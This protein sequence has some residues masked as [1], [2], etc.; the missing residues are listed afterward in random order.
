MSTSETAATSIDE[1][2]SGVELVVEMIALRHQIAAPKRCGTRRPCFRRW[3]RLFWILLS[4]WWPRWREALTIVQPETVLRWRR[5]G[6]S[7]L[8]QYRSRGRWQGG[9]PRISR[10]VRGL[11]VRM[12]RE[13]FLWGVPRIHG[14][15][16]MLGFKVSQA[17]VSRYMPKSDRRPGQSWRTFIRLQALAFTRQEDLETASDSEQFKP[18]NQSAGGT[19]L[20]VFCEAKRSISSLLELAK[21]SPSSPSSDAGSTLSCAS[22]AMPGITRAAFLRG[23]GF[24]E[25]QRSISHSYR[26]WNRNLTLTHLILPR[27][28]FSVGAAVP[29]ARG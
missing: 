7:G 9:R 15:L 18:Y 27:L 25:A 6:W 10:E 22:I 20:R 12:A 24:E 16:R 26:C 21:Q 11:I 2:R 14:E 4:R 5:T 8:W 1:S 23:P 28:E 17:T 3:D 19:E 29:N 13:N